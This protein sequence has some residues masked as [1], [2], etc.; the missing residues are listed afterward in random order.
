MTWAAVLLGVG[1]SVV[2]GAANVYLGLRV[3][4]TVSASIPAAVM[5]LAILN[6]MLRRTSVLEAN[7]VQ[8]GASAGE[9]LAAGVIFT[10]PALVLLGI[11]KT[12]DFWTTTAIAA[13]GGTLGVLLMIPMRRAFIVDRPELPY[14][15][16]VACAAVLKTAQRGD[17][18]RAGS[19][20]SLIF[21]GL[22]I[23]VAFKVCQSFLGLMKSS[24]EAAG[25]AGGRVLYFGADAAP[26]LIAVGAIVGL[27]IAVQIFLGGAIS[28]LVAI[29]LAFPVEATDRP[30]AEVAFGLWSTQVR[31]LGVGAMLVGGV[32]SIWQVRGGLAAA[33]R[34]LGGH[35]LRTND[36]RNAT[37][38]STER[39]LS[40]RTI[41]ALA[42]FTVAM[43]VGVYY[44]LL[45]SVSVTLVTTAVML[46]MAFF[47]TAVASYI[48]G[49]VGNSN[50]PVSGMTI[51]AV[52]G[53][54][55]FLY[56]L[57]AAGVLE[58]ET[59]AAILATLGVAGVIC[60]VACTS[61]DVCNDLKTGHLVGAT[62]R[63]QQIMQ[64]LGVAAGAVVMAPVLTV[65]HEGSLAQGTGGIGGTE[66]AAPQA[67]LFS[68]L[69]EG[70]FA[71]GELPWGM[72]GAG[73]LV[74]IGL[75][76]ADAALRATG[77]PFRLY[78]MPV[79]V[80]MYL[81]FGVAPPILLGGLLHFFLTRRRGA[82]SGVA[83]RLTLASSGIIAGESLA[84]VA[85]GLAAYLGYGSL[86]LAERLKLSDAALIAISLLALSAIVA[87]MVWSARRSGGPS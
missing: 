40:T 42:V 39:N 23:G 59:E 12:F 21:L 11:W 84:G 1:L 20:A 6:G 34:E 37:P 66:L 30:A 33:A 68:K 69:A 74:G 54:G 46:L 67:V 61:G 17:E 72:I 81:P 71:G 87:W 79:A 27:P 13:A 14:P 55:G 60:C 80:G 85:L 32:V 64:I 49:L 57:R 50:S 16:G 18:T 63:S 5:A 65:L 86:N 76:L 52:L 8:T 41:L 31:Y 45:D 29:P 15:E 3:G 25:F 51:T 38:A 82:H 75:V 19:G 78:V 26:V 77:V 2:M 56:L 62:P 10:L 36:T 24:L 70:M 4:M 9:S 7:M 28:W 73:V 48:V 44:S 58:M 47:F 83:G 43:I 35:F 53:T 22:A